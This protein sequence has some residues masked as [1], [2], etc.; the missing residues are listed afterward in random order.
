MALSDYLLGS[1][2]CDWGEAFAEWGWLLP[3]SLKVWFANRFG[4]PFVVM[5]DGSIHLLRVDDGELL[6]LA[7]D[8]AAFS[9]A[10]RR[11]GNAENWLRMSAVEDLVEAG[12]ELATGEC[13]GYI[14]PLVL[15]G[16]DSGDNL[17]RLGIGERI[18]TMGRVHRRIRFPDT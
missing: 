4:D 2:A 18:G 8:E 15:G 13:Y 3:P 1:D 5:E 17:I 9:E 12:K 6:R 16:Y 14:L 11:D 10:F 7:H